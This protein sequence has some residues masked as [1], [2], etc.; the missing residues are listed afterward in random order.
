MA[1]GYFLVLYGDSGSVRRVGPG[2]KKKERATI[3]HDY[4]KKQIPASWGNTSFVA[5]QD[6]RGGGDYQF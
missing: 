3:Q 1:L 4:Y 5:K 6:E 2:L